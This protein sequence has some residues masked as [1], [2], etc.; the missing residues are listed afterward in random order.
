MLAGLRAV[1][2]NIA[3]ASG[4]VTF[5]SFAY[6]TYK[7]V[8]IQQSA[9]E[10]GWQESEIYG[11]V[12][13]HSPEGVM[14]N[15]IHA[16]LNRRL[17]RMRQPLGLGLEEATTESV[18]AALMHL[19]ERGIVILREDYTYAAPMTPLDPPEADPAPPGGEAAAGRSGALVAP[20]FP[21]A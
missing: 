4:L 18:R 1:V 19:T 9:F 11:I 10:Q 17:E 12:F 13:E 2:T 16:E 5:A 20:A 15:D 14:F 6:S 21:R 7:D 3:A 8:R